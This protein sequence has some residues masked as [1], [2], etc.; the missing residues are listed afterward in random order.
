M[1]E[2]LRALKSRI[3]DAWWYPM[4][5]R[6]HTQR[7]DYDLTVIKGIHRKEVEANKRK[8]DERMDK[9]FSELREVRLQRIVDHRHFD[10]NSYVLAVSIDVA[11]NEMLHRAAYNDSYFKQ[12]IIWHLCRSIERELYTIDFMNAPQVEKAMPRISGFTNE[13]DM[14]GM[15]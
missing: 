1:K 6:T 3:K 15:P 10:R 13:S 8:E 7:L 4:T 14:P 12:E 11:V 2:W 5:N 9:F